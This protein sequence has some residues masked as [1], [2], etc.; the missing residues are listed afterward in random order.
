MD[1]EL[2][3]I[4]DVKALNQS[5]VSGANPVFTSI[6][7]LAGISVGAGGVT[8]SII[9]ALKSEGANNIVL[10]NRTKEKANELK[11]QFPEVLSRVIYFLKKFG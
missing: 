3:S 8:S 4:A 5:V 7:A 6:S 2:T 11:K 10:S 9:S 1:S